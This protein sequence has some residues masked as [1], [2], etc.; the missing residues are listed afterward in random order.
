MLFMG[1]YRPFHGL[2]QWA[3]SWALPMGLFMGFTNRPF[4]VLI[5]TCGMLLVVNLAFG[6]FSVFFWASFHGHF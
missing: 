2:Y 3:F 4:M 1:L 5:S 6:P